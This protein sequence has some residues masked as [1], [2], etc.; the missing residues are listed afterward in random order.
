MVP[1]VITRETTAMPA[2][3]SSAPTRPAGQCNWN[4]RAA[5]IAGFAV[6]CFVGVM[7][8]LKPIPQR[9]D[10]HAFADDRTWAGI[11]NALNVLSNIPFFLVAMAG[12]NWLRRWDAVYDQ[13][14]RPAYLTLF[15]GLAATALGSAYYHWAPTS[16]TLFWDRLPIALSFMGLFAAIIGERMG[17]RIGARLL[18]PLVLYAAG[19]V[20]YW[21]LSDDLRPYAIAQFFPLLAIPMLLSLFP[22]RFTR[23]AMLLVAIGGYV[24]AKLIEHADVTIYG[25]GQV[26]SGHTLKHLAAALGAW[27]VVHMLASR[28]PVTTSSL[29]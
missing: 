5:I 23:G 26:V 6:A 1:R 21:H 12:L 18:A 15:L 17:P 13:E 27:L 10:Y 24:F 7:L 8:G 19:S 11:P 25:V 28:R 29:S 4:C 2:S 9:L 20:L 16:E 3:L 22:A 14:L